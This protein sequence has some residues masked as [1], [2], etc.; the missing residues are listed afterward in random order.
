MNAL[1][2]L[3]PDLFI[4]LCLLLLLIIVI[5]VS[6]ITKTHKVYLAFHSIMMLWPL[7]QYIVSIAERTDVQRIFVKVSFVSIA[8]IGVSWLFFVLFLTQRTAW[9]TKPRIAG[10]LLPSLISIIAVVWNPNGLFFVSENEHF[11]ERQYGPM[12]WLLALIQFI[13]LSV[14]LF[15][16]YYT[17]RNDHSV[18]RRKQMM[19]TLFGMLVLTVFAV[20]DMLLNVVLQDRLPII[21]GLMSVGILLSDLCFVVVISR[22]GMFDV[23]SMAQKDIIDHMS[24]GIIVVDESNR[25]IEVN[26]GTE[27]FALVAKKD[28]FEMDKFLSAVEDQEEVREFLYRYRN[29]PYVRQQTEISWRDGRYVSIQISPVLDDM[30]SVLAKV[31]TFQDVTEQRKHVDDMNRK[32][33][34]LHER[35]L[36]LILIQEELFRVNQKLEQMAITDGLTGCYNR[37][38]LMQQLE[39][40]VMLNHRYQTPFSI[41]LFDIDHF[42]LFNDRYGHLIG[43]EVICKTVDTVRG[44]LRKTDILA[45]YGGEEFTIYLPHTNREQA[46]VLAERILRAVTEIEVDT[47][48]EKTG[49]TISMGTFTEE[50]FDT[51]IRDVKE[52]LRFIF[53]QV[54]TALYEAKNQGRNCIVVA[55]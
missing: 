12:F 14:T 35:N 20:L 6:Q 48:K 21:S 25:V 31:I 8:L 9:L 53:S 55:S 39:H 15:S 26:R 29:T 51:P 34:A 44:T 16:M 38:F 1:G 10:A 43:D 42:K 46:E 32:N 18:K 13:Y 24:M 37:R 33:E 41:F 45:R 28:V 36:E 7:G 2:L 23:L 27:P 49:I 5:S 54:D 4:F 52:Y 22:Y 3:R 47:G 30:K 40:E 50:S 11:A 17:M 19:L